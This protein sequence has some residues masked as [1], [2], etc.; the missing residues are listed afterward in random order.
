MGELENTGADT[1]NTVVG[2]GE[3][4]QEAGAA[5]ILGASSS[6]S[7]YDFSNVAREFDF[8]LDGEMTSNLVNVF[9]EAGKCGNHFDMAN[10]LLKTHIS[11][12]QAFRDEFMESYPKMLS[13]NDLAETKTYFG[14]ERVFNERVAKAG[15]ALQAIEKKVP[16]IRAVLERAGVGNNLHMLNALALIGEMVG[17]SGNFM[18]GGGG[19]QVEDTA[20]LYF[21]NSK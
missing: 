20:G 10:F 8:E 7:G 21:R 11:E 1:I 16:E 4:H 15:T 2:E 12:V 6:A 3:G 5:S 14:D 17:E 9:T 19:M 18:Y 13:E